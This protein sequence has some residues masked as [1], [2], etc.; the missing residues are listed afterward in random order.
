VDRVL[1]ALIGPTT[2]DV[3]GHGLPYLIVRRSRV[4]QKEGGCLHDLAGLTI[5]ALRHVQLSPGFLNRMIAGG[6]KAFD[7]RDFTICDIGDGCDAGPNGLF[8]DN[9]GA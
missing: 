5:A 2:T 4:F 8:V 3:A 9:D 7:G 1:D 6:M